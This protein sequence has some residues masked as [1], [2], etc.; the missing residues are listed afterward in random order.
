LNKLI[1]EI[2]A[3]LIS[4]INKVRLVNEADKPKT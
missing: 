1:N 4:L 3:M 2:K